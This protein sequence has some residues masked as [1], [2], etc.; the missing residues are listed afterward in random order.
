MR[1][2]VATGLEELDGSISGE[3]SSRDI[4]VVG[5]C[6]YREG[7]LSLAKDRGADVVILSTHLPGQADTV[8]LVK[9]LRMAGLR[10]ILL[11]GRRDDKKAVDLARKAVALGV[12][13]LVW[14]P[15][16][17]EAVVHR[18]LNPATLAEASVGPE[19]EVPGIAVKRPEKKVPFWRRLF[20]RTK[21]ASAERKTPGDDHPGAKTG[22]EPGAA[23]P[24]K[25]SGEGLP[26]AVGNSPRKAPLS[27]WLARSPTISP[28]KRA[29]RLLVVYSSASGVGKTAVSMT[30]AALLAGRGC[31]VCLVD[32]DPTGHTLTEHFAGLPA[33]RYAFEAVRPRGWT[34]DLVPGPVN[35][36]DY[37]R[38]SARMVMALRDRY[39]FMIVDSCPGTL[40]VYEHIREYL[41]AADHIWLLCTPEAKAVGAV[42]RFAMSEGRLVPSLEEKLT[43][44]V[45]RSYLLA[46]RKP[47]EVAAATGF[48]LG[49]VLPEDSFVESLFTGASPP[50]PGEKADFLDAVDR[51]AGGLAGGLKTE[52]GEDVIESQSRVRQRR[53]GL[54]VLEGARR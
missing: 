1:V 48:P 43:F 53:P 47:A 20:R 46:P 54:R 23:S 52:K 22:G 27:Y 12:Y 5:E 37:G 36:S 35:P 2:L 21:P 14:D 19:G 6:Y 3:L 7:L 8:D 40:E 17:P 25:M 15:V 51:L 41:A 11:S 50:R 9:E 30:T 28:E 29:G 38:D 10:V 49:A 4:E 32:A 45:N 16:S 26:G 39:D 31:R 24:E 18:V 42:K 34:F 33:G 44:V 13:D